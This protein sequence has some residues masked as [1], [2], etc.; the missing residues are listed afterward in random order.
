MNDPRGTYEDGYKFARQGG[1]PSTLRDKNGNITGYR[2]GVW[3][4]GF[5]QAQIDMREELRASGVS[6]MFPRRYKFTT[7]WDE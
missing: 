5:R 1:K 2:A 6:P 4:N 3:L 7:K